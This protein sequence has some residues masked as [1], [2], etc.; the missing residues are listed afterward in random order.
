M[1]GKDEENE[2]VVGSLSRWSSI[3]RWGDVERI[4]ICLGYVGVEL[5]VCDAM[6]CWCCGEFTVA[7][8][9]I[10]TAVAGS[11]SGRLAMSKAVTGVSMDADGSVNGLA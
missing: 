9:V 3:V 1:E 7:E 11:T 5:D 10:D 2:S 4:M 6:N 8:D